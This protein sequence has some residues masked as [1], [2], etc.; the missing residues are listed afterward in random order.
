MPLILLT[1]GFILIIFN[2]IAIKKEGNITNKSFN[3]IL[4]DSKNNINDYKLEIGILRKDIAESLTELQEEILDIKTKLKFVKGYDNIYENKSDEVDY[5]KLD[6]N[7]LDEVSKNIVN[8]KKEK[9]SENDGVISEIDFSEK[10]YSTNSKK[11][12]SI[13]DLL[14]EGLTDEEICHRLSVSKGEVLLVKGLFKN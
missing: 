7:N 6:N 9:K 1:F 8:D 4:K 2:Y 12:E 11:T 14:E 5:D 13:K 3:N 10:I